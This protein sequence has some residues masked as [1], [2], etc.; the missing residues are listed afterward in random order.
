MGA[1]SLEAERRG[2]DFLHNL[3][4]SHRNDAEEI[5]LLNK[6]PEGPPPKVKTKVPGESYLMADKKTRLKENL[7][8]VFALSDEEYKVVKDARK[9]R[10]QA[11][12]ARE[13]SKK[14]SGGFS[15]KLSLADTP[16][17]AELNQA[18]LASRRSAD[19]ARK[20]PV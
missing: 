20:I 18:P 9:R 2:F 16:A 3:A 15:I 7:T 1:A 4:F 6:P 12:S 13:K 14:T 10:Q 17:P 19:H 5:S 11:Q 8:A